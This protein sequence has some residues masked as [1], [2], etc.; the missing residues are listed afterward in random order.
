MNKIIF[1]DAYP[2]VHWDSDF[3]SDE[4]KKSKIISGKNVARKLFRLQ[5][6]AS[7]KATTN[8]LVSRVADQLL[9]KIEGEMQIVRAS[10]TNSIKKIKIEKRLNSLSNISFE[11]P[12]ESFKQYEII[13]D[14]P[15]NPRVMTFIRLFALLDEISVL[16]KTQY[17]TGILTKD[18]Y[19]RIERQAAKPLRK[20]ILDMHT[21]MK[22]FFH[23][24]QVKKDKTS[25]A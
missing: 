20:L 13:I 16:L 19:K 24:T 17:V 14:L 7:G 15:V 11:D 4:E 10:L 18:E 2:V 3:F 23:I 21:T 25:A 9:A 8:V 6:F 22:N 12:T 1:R 5:R